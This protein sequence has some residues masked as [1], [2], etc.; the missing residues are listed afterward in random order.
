MKFFVSATTQL[1]MKVLRYKIIL[2]YLLLESISGFTQNMAIGEWRIAVPYS[3]VRS[4]TDG[5][6]F[7]YAAANVF[8]FGYHKTENYPATYDKVNGLSDVDVSIVAYHSGLDVLLVAYEN[9]NIDLVYENKI[10][11][12]S[13]IKRASLTGKKTINSV[14]FSNNL[15]YLSCGFGIIV[16]N[17]EKEEIQATYYI[18]N[19]GTQ[20]E[21]FATTIHNNQLFAATAIGLQKVDL[22]VSN[23]ANYLFWQNTLPFPSSDVEVFND[24]VYAVSRDTLFAENGSNWNAIHS[25]TSF[26]IFNIRTSGNQLL[27]CET[28]TSINNSRVLGF[29][30]TT[31]SNV[32]PAGSGYGQIVDALFIND[33]VMYVADLYSGLFR[34]INGTRESLIPNGPGSGNIAR[35]AIKDKT[36]MF[37][38]GTVADAFVVP[39]VSQA[40]SGWWYNL[41]QYNV[42]GLEPFSSLIP[43]VF[44]A[45]GSKYYLGSYNKGIV[46]M[47]AGGYVTDTFTI[48]NTTMETTVGDASRCKVA[49]IAFDEQGNMWATNFGANKF[50]AVRKTDG[51]WQSFRP[52]SVSSASTVTDII[53]DDYGQKWMLS[54]GSGS[55]GIVVFSEGQDFTVTTD[56]VGKVLRKGAGLGNLPS[57]N[58]LAIAN[59]LEG[60]IWVGTDA[61]IAVFYCPGSVLGE[62]GCDAQ[63]ILVTAEDGFVGA[64]LGSERVQTIAVDGANRK[65][66]GTTNGVWLFSPDGTKQIHYFSDENSP[67]ISNN[68]TTIAVDPLDGLV[69]I[70]TDKGLMIYRSDATE[71]EEEPEKDKVLAFPNPV[72]E[73]YSGPIAIKGL[74]RDADV[75]ITDVAG[76]LVFKTTALGGQAI[77]DGKDGTGANAKGGVYLVFAADSEGK[78][79]VV[80]KILVMR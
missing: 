74:A 3:N 9:T 47:D 76:N 79:K 7:V 31:F 8:Y 14:Y 75:K 60:E 32:I 38:N 51:T 54:T 16:L 37:T 59:D 35:I 43:V 80:T 61:G 53:V 67:L 10:V 50:L 6:D 65:W 12:I 34:V 77:W 1:V 73:N 36:V 70:G 28:D 13:D 55:D 40:N 52:V 2:L 58:V 57:N 23:P 45:S 68:V 26:N 20:T 41:N 33:S 24:E 78:G 22:N 29:N 21:V 27:L 69:Y 11:N 15:A 49:G 64:L 56:D 72:R 42:N 17:L 18:G 71:A 48:Y 44:N 39:V 5:K 46:E 66:V 63:E 25:D 30:G 62:S 19:N 4:L